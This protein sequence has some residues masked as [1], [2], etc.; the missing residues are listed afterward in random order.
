[1]E[2]SVPELRLRRERTRM[3]LRAQRLMG[4]PKAYA[5]ALSEAASALAGL[6]TDSDESQ[7]IERPRRQRQ[8][9]RTIK[10]EIARGSQLGKYDSDWRDLLTRADS[11]NVF[12]QPRVL[13]AADGRRPIVALLAWEPQG[14][15]R[16]LV[17]FCR[18]HAAPFAGADRRAMRTGDGAR[19]PLGAGHRPR[20]A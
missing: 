13:R 8:R 4:L 6:L 14:N 15:G 11:Q 12:M 3:G 1:M 16:R 2:C 18:G 5:F 9:A 7:N 10:A 20:A 19:L 17:G